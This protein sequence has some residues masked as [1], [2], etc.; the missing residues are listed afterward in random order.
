MPEQVRPDLALL[1]RCE[2]NAVDA[3]RQSDH[4]LNKRKT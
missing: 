4:E 1:E 3:P 2:V